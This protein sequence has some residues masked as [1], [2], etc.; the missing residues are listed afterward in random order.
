MVQTNMLAGASGEI[1]TIDIESD[2][3]DR[4]TTVGNVSKGALLVQAVYTANVLVREGGS[5][6]QTL[7][8]EGNVGH[9]ARGVGV[10][11][12]EFSRQLHRH[13]L[14]SD[15]VHFDHA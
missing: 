15:V 6:V 8:R 11:L 1:S 7:V 2:R 13:F 14:V 3:V 4:V 9:F 5:H 10:S 12:R